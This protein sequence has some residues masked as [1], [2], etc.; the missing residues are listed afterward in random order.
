[1]GVLS[2]SSESWEETLKR[3]F[4]EIKDRVQTLMFQQAD[5]SPPDAEALVFPLEIAALEPLL[6]PFLK[7]LFDP[8]PYLHLPLFRGFF[9]SSGILG[10]AKFSRILGHDF[11]KGRSKEAEIVDPSVGSSKSLEDSAKSRPIP[12]LAGVV[13]TQGSLTRAGGKGLSLLSGAFL[14]DFFTRRLPED[15]DLAVPAGFIA[16]WRQMSANLL[17]MGWYGGT[18]VV[19]GY[20]VLSYVDAERTVKIMVSRQ[21]GPI[22]VEGNLHHNM[23]SMERYRGLIDWMGQ[24][25]VSLSSRVLA[26]S[27]ETGRLEDAMKRR[28]DKEFEAAI[29]PRLNNTL[30]NKVRNLLIEDPY[31]HLADYVDILVRRINLIKDRLGGDTFAVLKAR[32]QPGIQDITSLDPSV[33]PQEAR[34]FSEIYL[35]YISWAPV[36]P[37]HQN[38]ESLQSL[39]LD[40]EQTL[41]DF[42]WLADWVNIRDDVDRVTLTTFWKGTTKTITE[43]SVLPAYTN[44]GMKRIS[45]FLAELRKASP[46][47][48]P[49]DR[50]VKKFLAW[51]SFRKEVAWFDFIRG[52]SRGEETLGDVLQWK[53]AF[54]TLPGPQSPYLL[55][56]KRLDREFPKGRGDSSRPWKTLLQEYLQ[57]AK[58]H[59]PGSDFVSR[60]RSYAEAVNQSGR[61]G[62][63]GGPSEG[64]RFLK[65]L[66]DAG[67]AYETYS[68]GLSS[69]VAEGIQGRGHDLSLAAS[70]YSYSQN[71]SKKPPVLVETYDALETIRKNLLSSSDPQEKILWGLISGPFWTALDFIDREAACEIQDKWVAKVV[72]P[73]QASL[74]RQDLDHFLLDKGGAIP[75]FMDK[76]MAPFVRRTPTGYLFVVRDKRT[77]S[78]RPSFL[79]FVN[80]IINT[81]RILDLAQKKNEIAKMKRHLDLVN[82]R[83][84]L[85]KQE[86]SDQTQI[87]AMAKT[88]FPVEIKALPTDVNPESLTRPYLT[89]LTLECA[90]KKHV[91]NNLNLP[92][93]RAWEW[94]SLTCGKTSLEIRLGNLILDRDYPGG[95]GFIKFLQEFYQGSLTLTPADFPLKRKSLENLRLTTLTIHYHFKG[96][97][98][99]LVRYQDYLQAQ[100]SLEKVKD[101]I[102]RIDQELAIQDTNKLDDK[103]AALKSQPFAIDSLPSD[104]SLC[105]PGESSGVPAGNGRGTSPIPVSRERSG[106]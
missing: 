43:E 53:S 61:A 84:S 9:F 34:Y 6:H 14:K 47:T 8:S 35:A 69:A 90:E 56:A 99:L 4:G 103:K 70:Y 77:V 30:R 25:D 54:Q 92:V 80:D 64:Q 68:S 26:F 37:I 78:V 18:L 12:S 100:Q 45:G 91:L 55:V 39:L 75:A 79:V 67:R 15:R 31:H 19:A 22:S 105:L 93:R 42:H 48:F 89:R 57:I 17:L 60:I 83:Q 76:T 16:R 5:A 23:E 29:L 13:Q 102:A 106:T 94:S 46:E 62:I 85:G 41:P 44:K 11:A 27:S 74:S 95:N 81:Q 88:K 58:F 82:L 28:F 21:P 49:I 98:A 52:F 59:R 33:S 86:Q 96:I 87:L 104:I 65:A 32:P 40:V 38:L 20:L 51:Y 2:N 36:D 10:T 73:A 1:M 63:N 66:I 97:H 3:G 71:G 101:K 72:S 7:G 50:S 24:R